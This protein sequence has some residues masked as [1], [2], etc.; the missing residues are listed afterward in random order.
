MRQNRDPPP[1]PQ[2][3]IISDPTKPIK[4]YFSVP[5]EIAL[6]GV[7]ALKRATPQNLPFTIY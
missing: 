6:S 3:T 2:K 7:T 5:M 4:P 1:P